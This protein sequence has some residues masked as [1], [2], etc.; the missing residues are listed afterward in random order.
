MGCIVLFWFK[1]HISVVSCVLTGIPNPIYLA[2]QVADFLANSGASE[3]QISESTVRSIVATKIKH[4]LIQD[5][6]ATIGFRCVTS[7]IP[8]AERKPKS[9]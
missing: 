4:R 7:E 6:I 3:C 9:F 1:A 8:N 5:R 2:N